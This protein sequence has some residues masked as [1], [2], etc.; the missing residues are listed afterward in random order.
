MSR[1]IK[2][3]MC[4]QAYH[5]RTFSHGIFVLFWNGGRDEEQ[6]LDWQP[7]WLG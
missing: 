6:P 1:S 5:Q 7:D 4:I 3:M 2:M